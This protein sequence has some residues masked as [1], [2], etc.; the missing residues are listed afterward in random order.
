MAYPLREYVHTPSYHVK[1]HC[2]A[3]IH[4]HHRDE[5]VLPKA[6]VFGDTAGAC[7]LFHC[8]GHPPSLGPELHGVIT[9]VFPVPGSVL[10]ILKLT[11]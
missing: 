8:P 3:G 2:L 9:A 10:S 1:Y 6:V 4:N 11:E 7:S 5:R